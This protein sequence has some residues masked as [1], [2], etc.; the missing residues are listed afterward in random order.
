[1]GEV[2]TIASIIDTIKRPVPRA[3]SSKRAAAT[4][5]T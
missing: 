5:V 3:S 4:S 1:M 2:I